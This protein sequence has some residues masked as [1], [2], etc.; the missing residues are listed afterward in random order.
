[1]HV[2][3]KTT[4]IMM[5]VV[6]MSVSFVLVTTMRII[7]VSA[8]AQCVVGFGAQSC[9]YSN[10]NAELTM[11]YPI[12]LRVSDATAGASTFTANVMLGG[13]GPRTDR[14]SPCR[15][16]RMGVMPQ[17]MQNTYLTRTILL[18]TWDIP[19]PST[20]ILDVQH[21]FTKSTL[22]LPSAEESVISI[23]R[24]IYPKYQRGHLS[25]IIL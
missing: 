15:T 16:P 23:I 10:T 8:A 5:T 22:V 24:W 1:M 25:T 7:S 3:N 13:G 17:S 11:T 18:I 20:P 19:S 21:H 4:K 2:L 14:S 9:K 12:M 6:A